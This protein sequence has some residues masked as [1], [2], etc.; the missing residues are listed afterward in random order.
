METMTQVP[1]RR[2]RAKQLRLLIG[3]IIIA[4]AVVVLI[5]RANRSSMVYY[6]TVSELLNSKGA[7]RSGLRVTGKVVPGSIVRKDLDLHFSMTDGQKAVPVDYRG[8]VP[9]TFAEDGEVV[10]EGKYLGTGTFQASYLLAKCPSK[11]EASPDEPQEQHPS[12]VP[13]TS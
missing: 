1:R 13:K 8:V 7:D 9:D 5:A 11:Y 6:V 10:V 12:G 3:F 2:G 4:A